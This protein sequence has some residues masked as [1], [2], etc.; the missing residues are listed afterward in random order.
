MLIAYATIGKM[1]KPRNG[2]YRLVDS[3]DYETLVIIRNN[4]KSFTIRL[5]GELPRRTSPEMADFLYNTGEE[6][7]SY[8]LYKFPI[9]FWNDEEF[10]VF[11]DGVPPCHFEKT[12]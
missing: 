2:E 10:M 1:T 5:I 12:N 6:I 8:D 7:V 4:S 9:K 3:D 11:L